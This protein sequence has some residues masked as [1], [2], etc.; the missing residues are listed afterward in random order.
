[1]LGQLASH[2]FV[3]MQNDL[4]AAAVATSGANDYVFFTVAEAA[5]RL[6]RCEKTILARIKDGRLRASNDGTLERLQYRISQADLAAFHR[7]NCNR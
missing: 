5:K 6:K 4:K 2:L 1:M 7:V 3:L